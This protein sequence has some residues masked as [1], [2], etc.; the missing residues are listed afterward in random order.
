MPG[1]KHENPPLYHRIV[2]HLM[3]KGMSESHAWATAVNMVRKGCLTGDLNF[4]GL[5]H[6]DKGK[7]ADWCAAYTAWKKNHPGKSAKSV[8]R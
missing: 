1:V 8:A 3:A 7:R 5:Q 6:M 4:P 2:K